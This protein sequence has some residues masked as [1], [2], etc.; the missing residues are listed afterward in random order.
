MKQLF[1]VYAIPLPYLINLS[2]SQ[3]DFP[4]D[5]K[6]AKVLPIY[7]ADDEKQISNYRPI[8]ILPYFSKIYEKVIFNQIMNFIDNN[9][10]LYAIQ[11]GFR[12]GHSC[13]HA[14]ISLVDKIAK[15]LD[16][17]KIVVGMYFDIKKDFDTFALNT[18]R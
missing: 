13:S 11:F 16:N 10:I 14:I 7:K 5:L 12:K 15:A 2:I 17:G 6:L 1:D 8:T 3:G 9:I 4:N 18:S